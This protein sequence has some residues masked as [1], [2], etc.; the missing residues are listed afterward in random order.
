MNKI[1][2]NFIVSP[3]SSIITSLTK[4]STIVTSMPNTFMVRYK[5]WW[6]LTVHTLYIPDERTTAHPHSLTTAPQ[7]IVVIWISFNYWRGGFSV[8][9]PES[10][11]PCYSFGSNND[12][13]Y[14]NI[15]RGLV[16]AV[17][18]TSRTVP[19]IATRT[20]STTTTAKTMTTRSP[21]NKASMVSLG[22]AHRQQP[23]SRRNRFDTN[24][25]N[26]ATVCMLV[27]PHASQTGSRQGWSQRGAAVIDTDTVDPYS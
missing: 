20:T 16:V 26:P 25:Q 19:W 23:S 21:S 6:L 15:R 22:R 1:D 8:Y 27:S 11:N 9:G 2:C 18:V 5:R 13:I 10:K 7:E 24:V 12:N 17:V 4:N 3:N 14:N